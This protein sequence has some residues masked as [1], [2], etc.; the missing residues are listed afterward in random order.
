M[1]RFL[2]VFIS[3]LFLSINFGAVLYVNSTLLRQY[4]DAETTS[5]LFV[6]GAVGSILLFLIVPKL[7]EAF[8][9]RLLLFVS[10]ILVAGATLSLGLAQEANA[11]AIS[12]LIYSSFFFI[13]YYILDI[14]LEEVTRDT[15]TGEV[16]GGYMTILNLGIMLGPLM[17]TIL[18]T[19]NG[20]TP[21]YIA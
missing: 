4:F 12:F 15:N 14:F 6:L 20:L 18:S 17:L 1:L 10:L 5:I 3:V 11:V 7:I 21:I 13:I 19:L 16:R 8:G 2:S 9:K